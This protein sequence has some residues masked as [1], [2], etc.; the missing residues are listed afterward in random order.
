MNHNFF[1]HLSVEEQ[2]GSFHNLALVEI[3]AMSISMT[4]NHLFM[5]A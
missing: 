2:L 1:I 4:L 5:T 3:A